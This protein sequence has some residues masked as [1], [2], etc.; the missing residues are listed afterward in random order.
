MQ[1]G[2]SDSF[3]IMSQGRTGLPCRADHLCSFVSQVIDDLAATLAAAVLVRNSHELDIHHYTH[4][5]LLIATSYGTNFTT[6]QGRSMLK[7]KRAHA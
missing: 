6:P 7:R 5:P 2:M 3:G 4:V 1:H